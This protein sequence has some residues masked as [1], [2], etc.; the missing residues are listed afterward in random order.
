MPLLASIV[1]PT[2]N[3]RDLLAVTLKSLLNQT[4]DPNAYEVVVVDDGS[5]DETPTLIEEIRKDAPWR[6]NYIRQTNAG[7]AKARNVGILAAMGRYIIF[8]DSDMAVKPGYV[9][10]HLDAHA[11]PDLIVQGRI[12]RTEN[13]DNPTEERPKVSDASRA[14]FDTGNVSVERAKL[15][16]VGLFDTEF[17][18]YG[19]EDL[20]LGLRLT[21]AGLKVVRSK[22]ACSYH[23]KRALTAENI[24]ALVQLEKER[25]HT[26]VLFYRKHPITRVK[27]MTALSPVFFALDRIFTPFRWPEKPGVLRLL[28]RL[29]QS[30]HRGLYRFLLTI[31]R[32]HA[33]ANGLREGLDR[34]KHG[35]EQ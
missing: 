32:N 22:E 11:Q 26:A 19:W 13:F 15:I 4:A 9:Q 20:E 16:E 34:Q 1:M 7:R 6:L 24:P 2:Y 30:G 21:K 28:Q 5:T 23:L 12:I 27:M 33:Y 3:R 8:L 29:E 31:L 10:A 35:R 17:V 18:E 14:S 25:G